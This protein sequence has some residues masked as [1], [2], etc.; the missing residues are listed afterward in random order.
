MAILSKTTCIGEEVMIKY[1]E[2]IFK[3]KVYTKN[4][5][6]YLES[7]VS[8]LDIEIPFGLDA[9]INILP[10]RIPLQQELIS[11]NKKSIVMG[12][13]M[14]A[15]DNSFSL[16]VDQHSV[17]HKSLYLCAVVTSH[18]PYAD[19]SGLVSNIVTE[20]SKYGC[21]KIIINSLQ[22]TEQTMLH[23][24]AAPLYTIV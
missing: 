22:E 24:I 11:I 2:K 8:S 1:L 7:L 13:L 4:V 18:Y 17:A 9:T 12:I 6:K 16:V 23:F 5:R 21:P 10:N 20:W 15:G 3:H 14:E 19:R